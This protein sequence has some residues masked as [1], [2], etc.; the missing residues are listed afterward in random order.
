M[1]DPFGGLGEPTGSERMHLCQLTIKNSSSLALGLRVQGV[2]LRGFWVGVGSLGL[3]AF[4][5]L[6][7]GLLKG[8]RTASLVDEHQPAMPEAHV[9]S[10]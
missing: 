5:F 3:R 9:A 4:G 10:Y 7:A 1:L 2:G 6:C 8:L